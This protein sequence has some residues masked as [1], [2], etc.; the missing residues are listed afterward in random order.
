LINL[1]GH[2]VN[3]G[4]RASIYNAMPEAG[5]D[6]LVDFMQAFVVRHG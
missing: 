1:R 4:I 2:R 6:K 3:G 5:V